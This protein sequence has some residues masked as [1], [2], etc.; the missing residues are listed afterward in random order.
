MLLLIKK[1]ETGEVSTYPYTKDQLAAELEAGDWCNYTILSETQYS[2]FMKKVAY[3][4]D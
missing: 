3:S 2:D 4:F 1:S